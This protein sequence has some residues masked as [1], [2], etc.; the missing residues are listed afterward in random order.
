MAE[1]PGTARWSAAATLTLSILGSSVLPIPFAFSKMG[2]LV[3]LLTMAIVAGSNCL[4]SNLLLG[5]AFKTGNASYE[6]IAEAAGGRRWKAVTQ[7]SLILLLV[8]TLIGDWCLLSDVGPRALQRLTAPTPSPAW[9]VG[10]SGRG[11][12]IL[13]AMLVV[14][15]MCLL[16]RMR[17]LELAASAGATVIIAIIAI[18]VHAAISTG[19]PAI[20]TGELPL[21]TLQISKDLPEAFSILGYGFYLQPMM[22]PLLAE[23]PAGSLGVK[24][25]NQAMCLVTLIVAPA[26][27]GMLGIFG[28]ARYG[29]ATQGDM[30]VNTWLHGRAEGILDLA[31]TLYLSI[32]IPPMQMSLRYTLDCL[33]AGEHAPYSR[34]RHWAETL[35]IVL[36]T[37]ATSA[38]YPQYSEKIF[39]ITGATAVC[40]VCYVIP[41]AI[42][43]KLRARSRQPPES[44]MQAD[45]QDA[46]LED[47]AETPKL[48]IRARVWQGSF[49][50]VVVPLAVAAMGVLFSLAA[51]WVSTASW[52]HLPL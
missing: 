41:V 31:T 12:M 14:L 30:L 15:P 47:P 3:G 23:M 38:A 4:T 48:S 34:A 40:L 50:Q 19:F 52:I 21:Y 25:T 32:S 29:A 7:T 1:K 26:V 51:L 44:D 37:L 39:A 6:G 42:H 2:V 46:L 11:T 35:G 24:L 8:G 5:A 28:A 27:Y 9:L 13:L 17:S 36:A 16:R 43:L 10:S 20:A 45:A 33:I 22:L 49:G 18:V